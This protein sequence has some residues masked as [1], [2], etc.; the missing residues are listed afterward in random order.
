[1]K[2]DMAARE[3]LAVEI[4]INADGSLWIPW[5]SPEAT[6]LVVELWR[7]CMPGWEFPVGGANGNIYCG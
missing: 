4:I 5:F 3:R 2:A 6:G 7:A 1:M